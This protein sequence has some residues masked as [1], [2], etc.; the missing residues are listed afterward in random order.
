MADD[1]GSDIINKP[2]DLAETNKS[3]IPNREAT[4]DEVEIETIEKVYR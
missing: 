1:I 2:K 3:S 4:V